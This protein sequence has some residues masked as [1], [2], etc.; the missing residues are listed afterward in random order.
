MAPGE[1]GDFH[2]GGAMLA[3]KAKVPITPVAHDAGLYWGKRSFLKKSGVVRVKIGPP[4]STENKKARAVNEEAREWIENS[5]TLLLK[6][7]EKRIN[8]QK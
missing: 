6:A 8:L 3:V 1:S 4:I 5:M 2:P 7:P